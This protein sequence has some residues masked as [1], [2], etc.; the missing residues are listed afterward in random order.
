MFRLFVSNAQCKHII[1]GGCHDN[2]YL[3]MISQYK[4]DQD[5]AKRITLLETTPAER[6]YRQ[7]NMPITRFDS[8]FKN[9]PLDSTPKLQSSTTVPP[10]RSK[11]PV[12]E[13][14]PVARTPIIEAVPLAR[15]ATTENLPLARAATVPTPPAPAPAKQPTI[16][17]ATTP[18]PP[19]TTSY[20]TKTSSN[21]A[22]TV[23][24]DGFHG[25]TV[26]KRP[27][28]P[29][30]KSILLNS[31][32]QRIDSKLPNVDSSTKATLEARI[33]TLKVCNNFHLL[34]KCQGRCPFDH[35]PMGAKMLVSLFLSLS[36][37]PKSSRSI[38]W[39]THNHSWH[40]ATKPA[41]ASVPEG[42]AAVKP[43]V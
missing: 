18:T 17:A 19:T 2:G 3:P 16:V 30:P 14:K 24:S 32:D 12:K 4:Y 39:L 10:P 8:V 9:E 43:T 5:T 34:N 38:T 41:N 1:F 25:V 20:A 21:K 42:A 13:A 26:G 6:Q 36:I 23:D 27:T 33:A 22:V 7:V 31:L 40:S 28:L 29:D 15:V 35:E 37:P 11:S